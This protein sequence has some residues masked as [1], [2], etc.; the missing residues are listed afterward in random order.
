MSLRTYIGS[1][2]SQTT[3]DVKP[4]V[5]LTRSPTDT[6]LTAAT[7]TITATFNVSIIAFGGGIVFFKNSDIEGAV[8]NVSGSGST[9]TQ[10]ITLPSNRQGTLEYVV[11]ANSVSSTAGVLGPVDTTVLKVPFD[12]RG[13]DVELRRAIQARAITDTEQITAVWNQSVSNFVIG[14]ISATWNDEDNLTGTLD[15]FAGSGSSY[16]FDINYP[17]NGRGQVTITVAANA[18]DGSNNRTGPA[19]ARSII[20]PYDLKADTPTDEPASLTLSKPVGTYRWDT[21]TVEMLW[22]KTVQNFTDSDIEVTGATKGTLTQDSTDNKLWRLP[23]TF[24][25]S[26]TCT[27][28]VPKESAL[29]GTV[30][31]PAEDTSVTFSYNVITTAFPTIAGVTELVNI[32]EDIDDLDWLGSN[33]G[34]AFLGV[35]DMAVN[36]GRVYWNTQIQRKRLGADDEISQVDQ[37]ASTLNSVSTS[38]GSVTTHKI[39]PY[40]TTSPRSPV[41]YNSEL[42]YFVGSHYLY[43]GAVSAANKSLFENDIGWIIKPTSTNVSKV[44]LGFRSKTGRDERYDGIHGGTTSPMRIYDGGVLFYAG[45]SDLEYV[46]AEPPTQDTEADDIRAATE[47]TDWQLLY[48]SDKLFSR[49]DILETNGKKRLGSFGRISVNH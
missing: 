4:S 39:Y 2:V 33:A 25:G 32:T 19:A 8:G 22:S 28:K 43:D 20:I 13:P 35:S 24:T 44:F 18:A 36:G 21:Y 49:I 23:L 47:I 5:T 48:F 17:A 12:T 14:D 38:G 10:Q 45:R 42:L 1:I 7:V 40:I 29:A 37:S 26:G 16:T 6:I 46:D 15:N 3:S 9:F 31:S 27:V 30:L 11:T 34:G 41:I